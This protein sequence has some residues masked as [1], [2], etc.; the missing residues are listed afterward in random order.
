MQLSVQRFNFLWTHYL[1]SKSK[2]FNHSIGQI[3]EKLVE[4]DA[5]KN[6]K[7]R[8]IANALKIDI[9]EVKKM[10]LDKYLMA[11][12]EAELVIQDDLRT[13]SLATQIAIAKILKQINKN[14]G[15]NNGGNV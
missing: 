15:E 11:E 14:G 10:P 12:K 5:K 6:V 3:D 2:Y 4:K 7:Y 9:S 8:Q 13:Q 1:K